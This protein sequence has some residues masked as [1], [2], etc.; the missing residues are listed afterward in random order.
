MLLDEAVSIAIKPGKIRRVTTLED[1]GEVL[2]YD[3]PG[4]TDTTKHRAARRAVLKAMQ[5][6]KERVETAKA[7]K[8]LEEA[9][10]EAGILAV[11]RW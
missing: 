2:I 3:W 7:R 9:A 1:A 8:A 10:S 5:S 4:R 6:A 11:N